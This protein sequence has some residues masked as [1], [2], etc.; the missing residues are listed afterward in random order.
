M[1]E[2]YAL[3]SSTRIAL[4]VVGC[5]LIAAQSAC[6]LYAVHAREVN[7]RLWVLLTEWSV[8]PN[9]FLLAFLPAAAQL[10]IEEGL[11]VYAAY[12]VPRYVCGLLAIS[13]GLGCGMASRRIDMMGNGLIAILLLPCM[14]PYGFFMPRLLGMLLYSMVRTGIC[15][16]MLYRRQKR[17]VTYASIKEAIDQLPGGLMFYESNG[18]IRLINQR[19]T[20]LIA[21]I[22]GRQVRSGLDFWNALQNESPSA[23][24]IMKEVDGHV[25]R[26]TRFPAQKKGR[27]IFGLRAVDVTELWEKHRA[28][29]EKQT[30]ILQGNEAIREM[31]G[32]I[33]KIRLARE[34]AHTWR[35]VHDVLGLRISLL[36]RLLHEEQLPD[37]GALLPLMEN[38]LEDI[39]GDGQ[40]S[41]QILLS[42]VIDTFAAI[43]IQIHTDDPLPMDPETAYVFVTAIREAATNAVRH[44]QARN[45]FIHLSTI[46]RLSELRIENDGTPPAQVMEGDGLTGIR[47]RVESLDGEMRVHTQPRFALELSL[48]ERK[49]P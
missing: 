9:Y 28:L 10:A 26:F 23:E 12:D 11:I 42:E 8:L 45:V 38:I 36:Q 29:A 34:A 44:A 48:P 49:K 47:L 15:G 7:E 18:F 13:F 37:I 4:A 30:E 2:L 32:N 39:R 27:T 25:W 40:Q 14:D 33:E 5:V 22:M 24:F 17:E 31:I 20:S 19:M 21:D 41:A 46:D 16:M 43:G 6:A 35:Q 3:A 1:L